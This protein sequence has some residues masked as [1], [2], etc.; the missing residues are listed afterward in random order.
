MAL[1]MNGVHLGPS[2]L[3][4][5]VQ[6]L[7]A[8]EKLEASRALEPGLWQKLSSETPESASQNFPGG[9]DIDGQYCP[10]GAEDSEQSEHIEDGLD[11]FLQ[12]EPEPHSCNGAANV[13]ASGD[14]S[15]QSGLRQQS[16]C[17]GRQSAASKSVR[18]LVKA[19]AKWQQEKD[20]GQI[21]EENLTT[22]ILGSRVAQQLRDCL[23]VDF[24]DESF[25][26]SVLRRC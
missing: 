16:G 11:A 4:G 3:A 24:C 18:N 2:D 10:A 8:A 25:L 13:G 17:Q 5:S 23:G 6:T 14:F 22:R 15:N 7:E 26:A 1:A 9:G 20:N 21:S 12:C 19:A